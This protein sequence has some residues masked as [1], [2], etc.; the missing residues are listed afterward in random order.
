MSENINNTNKQITRTWLAG[1]CSC[2]LVIP[3]DFARDYGLDRPCHVI[4]EKK[5][6]GILIR[7][8]KI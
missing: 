4:L 5:A 3:K 7:K 1:H 6:D 8:L 2:T